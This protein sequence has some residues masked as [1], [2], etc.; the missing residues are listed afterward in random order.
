[1]ASGQRYIRVVAA[2]KG[3]EDTG[4]EREGDMAESTWRKGGGG[5]GSSMWAEEEE[6]VG[7]VPATFHAPPESNSARCPPAKLILVAN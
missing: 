5:G 4:P 1:M 6:V 7:A 2:R 3:R